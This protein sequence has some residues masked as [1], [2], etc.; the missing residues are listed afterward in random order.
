MLQPPQAIG[1]GGERR[2]M[3][4]RDAEYFRACFD[5]GLVKSPFLEVGSAKVLGEQLT[6]LC[7]LATSYGVGRASGVDLAQGSGVDYIADFSL[8][9]DIFRR[10]WRHG[11]FATVAIFNV[12]EHTFD[13]ITVLSNALSCVGEQGT[14]LALT[15]T[16]WEIHNYPKDYNRLLPDWYHAFAKVNGLELHERQFCWIS[17]F[18]LTRV[19]DLRIGDLYVFPTYQNRGRAQ[20]ARR[21]WTSR[22]VH[23]AF[24]TYGRSHWWTNV[25]LGAAFS[26]RPQSC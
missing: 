11:T 22:I 25:A 20:S 9:P 10:Q 2:G 24:N 19:N 21:Y 18:G 4:S 7:E 6:N 8:P 5:A 12:L 14:L 26:K 17:E 23:R 16:I 13:P 15:P 1:C 3:T